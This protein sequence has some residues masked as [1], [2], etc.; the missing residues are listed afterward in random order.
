[1]NRNMSARKSPI[2][3]TNVAQS[4]IV[5]KYIPQDEGRKS[6]WRL[7][8]TMTNRSSHIPIDTTTAIPNSTGGLV[9][10]R[11]NQ[12]SCGATMLQSISDQ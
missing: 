5:G 6:R 2:V 11:L 10:T 3:P 7:V 8:T 9:R 1:M 4:Q 12:R